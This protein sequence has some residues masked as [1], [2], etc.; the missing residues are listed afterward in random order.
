MRRLGILAVP[1]VVLTMPTVT[2]TR[3]H[4]YVEF[5]NP[6]LVCDR[7]YGAV[8]RWHNSDACG[9]DAKWWNEP[10]GH[11]AP[12]HSVCQTWDPVSGCQ[13]PGSFPHS[14]P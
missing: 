13:C 14:T 5:A 2:H 1:P 3:T 6:H 10:C 9:C 8:P 7:C 12:I 11:T 4:V